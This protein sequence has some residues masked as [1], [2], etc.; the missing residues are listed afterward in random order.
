MHET[1]NSPQKPEAKKDIK[2][3]IRDS[4]QQQTW[5]Q[6]QG[7]KVAITRKRRSV[8]ADTFIHIVPIAIT[9][10]LLS[11]NFNHVFFKNEDNT[12]VQAL[13][14]S[15]QFG[16][17]LH[18]VLIAASL[19][20]IVLYRVRRE[21]LKPNAK[22]VAL[23][24][25]TVPY[26]LSDITLLASTQFWGA[27]TSPR[28]GGVRLLEWLP[29]TI[30]LIAGL[31][32]VAVVGPSSAIL[33]VPALN[34][35]E[36]KSPF[37]G[38]P[39]SVYT[40][41]SSSDLWPQSITADLL[42]D[43][44]LNASDASLQ[45]YCP[46][47]GYGAISSWVAGNMKQRQVGNITMAN[48]DGSSAVRYLTGTTNAPWYA[49][50]GGSVASTIGVKQA[51][52][53]ASLAWYGSLTDQPFSSKLGYTRIEPFFPDGQSIMKPFV[54]VQCGYNVV[55]NQT[56]YIFP[57]DTLQIPPFDTLI[58]PV[59]YVPDAILSQVLNGGDELG[60][61]SF[62]WVD[63]QQYRGEPSIG[64][65]F[66]FN[67]PSN[68]VILPCVVD[69]RWVPVE[70][71]LEPKSD[72]SIR[73]NSTDPGLLLQRILKK[74]VPVG[75]PIHISP[76]WADA[77]NPGGPNRQVLA[78]L[79]A[80]LVNIPDMLQHWGYNLTNHQDDSKYFAIGPPVTDA[81]YPFVVS[82]MLGLYL[83]DALARVNSF[84]ISAL[85]DPVLGEGTGFTSWVNNNNTI[86][87]ENL[88]GIGISVREW[89]GKAVE[90]GWSGWTETQFHLL[91]NGYGW[92]LEGATMWLAVA[93]LLIQAIIGLAHIVSIWINKTS[94]RSWQ[95]MT[96]LLALAMNSKPS[97][98]LQGT[99]AGIEGAQPFR[100][101]VIIREA[102]PDHL[103]L[104]VQG[105][106]GIG[107]V[108][109]VTEDKNYR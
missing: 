55:G 44:C 26:E 35:F 10:V 70:M 5:H 93:I 27:L 36:V 107:S 29:M 2:V 48:D 18:E 16:A 98:R 56:S 109:E 43:G 39:I 23:G 85:H 58:D 89:A 34:W 60:N 99:S 64:A 15:F 68:L 25:V 96:E 59:W 32:L 72:Y 75:K 100:E 7:G 78:D 71:W 47:A 1:V 30:L 65:V 54:Q 22:G 63:M 86:Y 87:L 4:E 17:K 50:K 62:A 80:T 83:T 19:T 82:N 104:I 9:A 42:P 38:G 90:S 66:A 94:S 33:M 53:L 95:S 76:G 91:R 97:E 61:N 21:L 79:S 74:K 92:Q 57:H 37:K 49:S 28:R 84:P 108:K 103:E 45:H 31:F 11:L 46:S 20:S 77:L 88:N 73:Q 13:L 81:E 51:R 24:F 52:D 8:L 67:S 102:E 14:N 3:H 6:S 40:N 101:M 69:A 12:H 106:E 105:S 41:I